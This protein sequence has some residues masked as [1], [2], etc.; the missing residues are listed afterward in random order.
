M[1]TPEM[2]K[3]VEPV[4]VSDYGKDFDD[5]YLDLVKKGYVCPNEYAK[6]RRL[7][8]LFAAEEVLNTI[9]CN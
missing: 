7:Y 5:K 1:E 3:E 8:C 6:H 4:K 2:P 9:V